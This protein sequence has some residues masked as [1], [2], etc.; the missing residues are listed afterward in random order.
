MK[1][2]KYILIMDYFSRFI[3]VIKLESMT[4]GA[5]IEALKSVFSHY[6]IPEIIMSDSGPQYSS[7]EFKVSAK[8][9][10]FSHVSPLLPQSNG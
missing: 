4:S 7:I 2:F 10:N 5:I 8:K 6:G 1:S 9:C 3:E